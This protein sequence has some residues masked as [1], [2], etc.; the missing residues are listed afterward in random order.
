[1]KIPDRGIAL[2]IS[3]TVSDAA[4]DVDGAQNVVR[5]DAHTVIVPAVADRLTV[6]VQ[7]V[8]AAAFGD[9][10]VVYLM[11]GPD[12]PGQVDPVRVEFDPVNVSG[13]G[14]TKLATL[15]HRGSKIEVAVRAVADVPLSPLAGLARAAARRISGGRQP[16]REGSL[17]VGVDTSA[18]MRWAFDDGSVA[19]AVDLVVGVA[20]VVGIRDISVTLVGARGE[21][22]NAPVAELA[23][24]LTSRQP[25]WS[26]GARW[27]TLPRAQH[28]LVVTDSLN[29]HT[30]VG[31]PALW[32]SSDERLR[33]VGPL[34]APPP[35]GVTADR[36]LADHPALVDEIATALLR[37]M[38]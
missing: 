12:S 9:D 1:M 2:S 8:G 24:A 26:A 33:S 10:T 7:P 31:L 30:L 16:P 5:V 22:V 13:S 29:P 14:A 21:T 20:D 23:Q 15:T 4:L 11:I 37:I 28:T 25:R 18:S 32:I 27:S 17:S 36:H 3:G 6:G 38:V 35:E 19:A 34:L